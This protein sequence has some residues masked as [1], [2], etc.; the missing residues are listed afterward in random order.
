MTDVSCGLVVVVMTD[1]RCGLVVEAMTDV[2]SASNACRALALAFHS[3][4]TVTEPLHRKIHRV[5][6]GH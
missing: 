6:S 1:V 2:S 5:Y 3:T 4:E